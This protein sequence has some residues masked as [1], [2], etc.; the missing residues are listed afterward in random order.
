MK[1]NNVN[2]VNENRTPCGLILASSLLLDVFVIF[3]YVYD[4]SMDIVL[5]CVFLSVFLFFLYALCFYK[6]KKNTADK[7]E[8]INKKLMCC[9]RFNHVFNCFYLLIDFVFYVFKYIGRIFL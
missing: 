2:D 1:N 6:N 8:K 5:L 4:Y 3:L 9:E 7:D